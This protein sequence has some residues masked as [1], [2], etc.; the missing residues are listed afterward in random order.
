MKKIRGFKIKLRKREI[1]RNLK[2]T[3]RVENI[4]EKTEKIIQQQVENTYSLIYPSAVYDTYLKSSE[5]FKNL[6]DDI[7]FGSEKAEGIVKDSFAVT[8][9]AATIGKE[10]ER[11]I[12]RLKKDDLTRAFILD[13]GASEAAEQ[14]VNFISRIIRREAKAEECYLSN[15]IS[16]GYGDWPLEASRSLIEKL[17]VEKIDIKI[18]P[19]SNILEPRKSITAL[20]GWIQE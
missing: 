14:S 18:N 1:L 15:R 5:E 2:Y 3:S 11:E 16:P 12:N 6:K 8:I 9:M 4:D 20:Q 17:P 19:E 10:I 13:A 7:L